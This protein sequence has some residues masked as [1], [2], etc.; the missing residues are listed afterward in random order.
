MMRH[1]YSWCIMRLECSWCI[2]SIHDAAWVRMMHHEDSWFSM[3]TQMHHE[4]SWCIMSTYDAFNLGGTV[5][6]QGSVWRQ[7]RPP[8]KILEV[9]CLQ[10]T[11]GDI[12]NHG[13]CLLSVSRYSIRRNSVESIPNRSLVTFQSSVLLMGKSRPRKT[14]SLLTGAVY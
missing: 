11:F 2:R 13:N 10:V 4:Y 6:H 8:R 9:F 14:A 1:E 7:L 3:S 5:D 12:Q